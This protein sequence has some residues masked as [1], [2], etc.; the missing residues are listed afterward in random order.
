MDSLND[1][2]TKKRAMILKKPSGTI[3][4]SGNLDV[5]ERKFY[6]MFL[7][8]AEETLKQDPKRH[9]FKTT[10]TELKQALNVE[11][12]DKH[13]IDYKKII[14]RMGDIKLEYNIFEKDNYIE[15]IASLLDNIEIKTDK[16]TKFVTIIYSIP[17]KVRQSMINKNGIYGS[18]DLMIIKGLKSK[19]SIIL[20]EFAKDYQKAELPKM[21]MQDFK[22]AF[23]IE[24]RYEGRIDHLKTYVLDVAT[25]ELNNNK[26]IDFLVDYELIKAGKVYTNIKFKIK[27]KPMKI[28][29][30]LQTKQ[31][32]SQ[33]LENEDLKEIL[34]YIP[35]Q[36]MNTQK[37]VSLILSGLNS[38]GK[39]YTIAQVKYCAERYGKNKVNNFVAYLNKALEEDYA[40]FEKIDVGIVR[41]EDAV[42][43]RLRRKKDDGTK[44]AF[45]ISDVVKSVTEGKYH[46]CFKNLDTNKEEWAMMDEDW[47][48]NIAKKK[49]EL[50]KSSAKSEEA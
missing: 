31:L 42:G 15:G 35:R 20:Y 3:A 30:P 5:R 9:I 8:I 32:E 33:S 12:N 16:I 17:E 26:N 11:E 10:L 36:Y 44:S 39:D 22:K 1:V 25:N 47:I 24:K 23:G 21:T 48:L 37:V 14:K 46:V 50:S 2:K 28:K 38:K 19:Y 13:N 45:V 4:V 6:N 27:P 29:E 43:C 18:I 7:K 34:I 40:G 41:F 49:I